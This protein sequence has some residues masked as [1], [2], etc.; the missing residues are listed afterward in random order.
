MLLCCTFDGII[1]KSHQVKISETAIV[2]RIM[3]EAIVIE[4]L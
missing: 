3:Y 1:T 2:V 4:I